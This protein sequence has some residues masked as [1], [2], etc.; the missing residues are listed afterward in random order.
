V[1]DLLGRDL[2]DGDLLGRSNSAGDDPDV[3]EGELLGEE[4][5]DEE[6]W[7]AERVP[8]SVEITADFPTVEDPLAN[9]QAFLAEVA[10]AGAE[11]ILVPIE[12]SP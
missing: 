2:A 8:P 9:E 10:A 3:I 6:N 4:D 5:Y 1:R 12:E 7:F 11:G